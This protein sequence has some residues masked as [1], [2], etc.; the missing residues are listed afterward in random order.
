MPSTCDRHPSLRI[1]EPEI[2]EYGRPS[3]KP[4]KTWA[5]PDPAPSA[6][7]GRSI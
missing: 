1:D 5:D 7:P 3:G 2:D 6:G 4:D